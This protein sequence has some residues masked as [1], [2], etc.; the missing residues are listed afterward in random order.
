[1]P[2]PHGMASFGHS[3]RRLAAPN[4]PPSPSVRRHRL[5]RASHFRR[6]RR[7][8]TY[9]GYGKLY[10]DV[11]FRKLVAMTEGAQIA[12]TRL[13]GEFSSPSTVR[14]KPFGAAAA[15][16]PVAKVNSAQSDFRPRSVAFAALPTANLTARFPPRSRSGVCASASPCY[17]AGRRR[18]VLVGSEAPVRSGSNAPTKSTPMERETSWIF[19]ILSSRPGA[20]C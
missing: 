19:T 16:R 12:R 10:P 9:A 20:R 18:L 3:G 13:S 15:S 8:D 6:D 17:S 5:P 7:F 1:M 4:P 11:S 2:W 14:T